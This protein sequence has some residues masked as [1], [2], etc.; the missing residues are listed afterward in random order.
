[1][2]RI[3]V[4][5]LTL[6]ALLVPVSVSAQRIEVGAS[7]GRGTGGSEGS[8]SRGNTTTMP[9]VRASVWWGD[10]V[11]TGVRVAW[12]PLPNPDG[13]A[14]YTPNCR[15]DGP[16]ACES[17][18]VN[19]DAVTPRRFTSAEVI[20]HFRPGHRLRPFAG[21]GYGRMD[22]SVD[23]SC[24]VPGC[25]PLFS[26]DFRWG[27]QTSSAAEVIAIGGLSYALTRHLHLRGGIHVHGG[28]EE[29]TMIETSV[30]VGVR[31]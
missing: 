27:R 25:E 5:I 26:P 11:E 17:Y 19:I 7:I 23:V 8:P 14:D 9:G 28:G 16:A 18:Y 2:T 4:A 30:S 31:F 13:R 1:M 15:L 20:Y 22:T 6:T 21:G 29:R 12:W 10:Q 3:P 24:A